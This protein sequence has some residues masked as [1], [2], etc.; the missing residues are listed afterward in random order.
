MGQER[1]VH[2]DHGRGNNFD[3]FQSYRKDSSNS[4]L[5]EKTKGL[6]ILFGIFCVADSD[7]VSGNL[8]LVLRRDSGYNIVIKI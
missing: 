1:K 3:V 2:A 6:W 4:D 8:N 5:G 7:R